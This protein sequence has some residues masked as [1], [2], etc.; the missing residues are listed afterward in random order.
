MLASTYGGAY[1]GTGFC[2]LFG[3]GM[4]VEV[5]HILRHHDGVDALGDGCGGGSVGH[6]LLFELTR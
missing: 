4:T 6:F 1:G 3:V 2:K 5:I